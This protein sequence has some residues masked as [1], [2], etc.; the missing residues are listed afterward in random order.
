MPT[1]SM[2]ANGGVDHNAT[3]VDE[4]NS[5]GIITIQAGKSQLS[6]LNL[7]DPLHHNQQFKKCG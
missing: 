2:S 3:F 1:T 6:K 4:L 5:N 7:P